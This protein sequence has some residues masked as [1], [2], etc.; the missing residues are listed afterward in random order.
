MADI[1]TTPPHAAVVLLH[2]ETD[3][4]SLVIPAHYR[5][6]PSPIPLPPPSPNLKQTHFT[7]AVRPLIA[8]QLQFY[9]ITEL[10]V[11]QKFGL[12]IPS[13]LWPQLAVIKDADL[14]KKG[15]PEDIPVFPDSSTRRKDYHRVRLSDKAEGKKTQLPLFV[16]S[17]TLSF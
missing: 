2:Q 1:T 6:C 12:D 4:D 14:W 3:S 11:A 5:A 13:H 10:P 8:R 16:D 7:N 17:Q 9:R 15:K